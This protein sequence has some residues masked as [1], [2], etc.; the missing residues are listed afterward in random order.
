MIDM[1]A[2]LHAM[3]SGWCLKNNMSEEEQDGME[4]HT[5]FLPYCDNDRAT[6]ECLYLFSHWSNDLL[7]VAADFGITTELIDGKF[8]VVDTPPRPSEKHWFDCGGYEWDKETETS[9]WTPGVWR[10]PLEEI[11]EGTY[12]MEVSCD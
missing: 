6:A 2:V 3:L 4:D 9:T 1:K 5:Y 11:P 10:E 12:D 8:Q 7:S